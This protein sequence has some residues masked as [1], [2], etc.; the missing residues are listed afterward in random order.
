MLLDHDP[1]KDATSTRKFPY[2]K[3]EII[4]EARNP[5][6]FWRLRLA[7]GKLPKELEGDYTSIHEVEKA[8]K[9]FVAETMIAQESEEAEKVE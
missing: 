4:A 7:N 3:T 9:P 5:Y 2:K 6:G 8:V 1:T